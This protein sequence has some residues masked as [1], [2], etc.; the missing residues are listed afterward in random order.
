MAESSAATKNESIEITT[1]KR[2]FPLTAI[3]PS[4]EREGADG[5][6]ITGRDIRKP[7]WES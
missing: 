5:F 3:S 1:G 7:E 2:P 6:G 4:R